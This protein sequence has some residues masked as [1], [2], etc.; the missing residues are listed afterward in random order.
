MSSWYMAKAQNDDIAIS[1]RIRLARNIEGLPFPSR[2]SDEDRKALSEKVKKAILE[3]NTPF[4]KSLKFIKSHCI[5]S[6]LE[7]KSNFF[8]IR[9][10]IINN[11]I[12]I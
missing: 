12:F 5:I 10:K 3:S 11:P 1:S 4:S 7:T 2:M 8:F 6:L 9:P